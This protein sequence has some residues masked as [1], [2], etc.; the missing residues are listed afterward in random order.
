MTQ[1]PDTLQILDTFKKSYLSNT[2]VTF[3]ICYA[4]DQ[5]TVRM[6]KDM[7]HTKWCVSTT[8]PHHWL[9]H[10]ETC[11]MSS[12]AC[13]VPCVDSL[14]SLWRTKNTHSETFSDV[15]FSETACL[16]QQFEEKWKWWSFL[17]YVCIDGPSCFRCHLLS[18]CT[19]HWVFLLV[20]LVSSGDC[21]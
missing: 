13:T 15:A 14:A 10:W 3:D 9:V 4:R 6:Y 8:I 5:H 12:F 7:L 2:P 11:P 17:Q 18:A 21:V 19:A 20:I 1:V 16:S